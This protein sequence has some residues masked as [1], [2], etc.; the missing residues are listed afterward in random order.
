M[1]FYGLS[2]GGKTA[3]RVPAVLPRYCLS[4]CSGDFNE[5]TWK[6]ASV[7]FRGSYM[8]TGEYEMPEFNMGHTIVYAEMA[9]LIAPR[10]FMVERGHDDGVGIDEWVAYEY[11]KV[12]RLY[13]K[14]GIGDR[15]EIEFFNGGHEINGKGTFAFLQRHLGWPK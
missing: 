9:A 11:A 10:P 15:T 8:F 5:W 2:Y 3:M 12:R 13:D 14:L 1:A 6:N 7:D 4:I